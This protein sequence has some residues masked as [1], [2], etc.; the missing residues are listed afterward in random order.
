MRFFVPAFAVIFAACV[1][2]TSARLQGEEP[3]TPFIELQSGP[4]T[5]GLT[6]DESPRPVH[7]VRL[8]VDASLERGKL[9]LDGNNPVFNEFGEVI[10]GIQT[11]QVRAQGKATLILELDCT[12]K[13]VKE[14]PDN[15]R[16]YRIKGPKIRTPLRIAARGSLGGG[17]PARMIVLGAEGKVQTVVECTRYG[18]VIP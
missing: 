4:L 11:P 12:I 15:W 13:M 2:L 1:A 8:V 14:G 7:Q 3:I 5:P 10:G 17:G 18:L 9:V 16:L 6:L